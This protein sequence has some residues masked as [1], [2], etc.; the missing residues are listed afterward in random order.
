M[1]HLVK[2]GGCAWFY[3][4]RVAYQNLSPTTIGTW[5]A[6]ALLEGQRGDVCSLGPLPPSQ[7]F[8]VLIVAQQAVSGAELGLLAALRLDFWLWEHFAVWL[9]SLKPGSLEIPQEDK[10]QSGYPRC[11]LKE[12]V[13]GSSTSKRACFCG[14]LILGVDVFY[15]DELTV[16]VSR[17]LQWLP[18]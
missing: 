18:S 9:R 13:V 12:S 10:D 7:E 5:R 1:Y 4:T 2:Y 15:Y 16:L 8:G 14:H 17:S 3:P 11:Y 6:C